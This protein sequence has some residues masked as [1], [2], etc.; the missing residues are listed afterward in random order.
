[1]IQV[2]RTL[3]FAFRL[4]GVG[5]QFGPQ[6][7]LCLVTAFPHCWKWLVLSPCLPMHGFPMMSFNFSMLLACA[8]DVSAAHLHPDLVMMPASL[9][10][11]SL[12]SLYIITALHFATLNSLTTDDRSS[13]NCPDLIFSPIDVKLGGILSH[14]Q[15]FSFTRLSTPSTDVIG[16]S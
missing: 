12:E 11:S 16:T 13:C 14:L 7:L 4:P 6:P 2:P 5:P 1:M 9:T 8:T 10:F 3:T 15:R